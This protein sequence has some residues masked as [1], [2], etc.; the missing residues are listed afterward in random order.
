[1]TN[2]KSAQWSPENERWG[3]YILEQGAENIP[4]LGVH[5]HACSETV[6]LYLR[7]DTNGTEWGLLE[8]G[9]PLT[10]IRQEMDHNLGS[11]A[12]LSSEVCDE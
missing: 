1:M 12:L 8:K 6:D 9:I 11:R 7:R 3:E 2:P 4:V 10:W 5:I